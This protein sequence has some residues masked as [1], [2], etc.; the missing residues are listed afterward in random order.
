MIRY[1]RNCCVTT[2]LTPQ[3]FE[4]FKKIAKES[5]VSASALLRGIIVDLIAEHQENKDTAVV[6]YTTAN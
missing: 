2:V 5:N 1:R 4:A 6:D 3:D